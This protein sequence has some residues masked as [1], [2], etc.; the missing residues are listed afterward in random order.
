MIQRYNEQNENKTGICLKSK[1]KYSINVQGDWI[2]H[3]HIFLLH[4]STFPQD[5]ISL[6]LIKLYAFHI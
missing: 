1:L 5:E 6:H 2:S 4:S 3:L